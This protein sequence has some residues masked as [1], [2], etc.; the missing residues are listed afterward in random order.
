M[1]RKTALDKLNEAISGILSEYADDVAGNLEQ[2]AADMGKKGA[3]ALRSKS[4]ETFPV[5]KTRKITG[6]YAKGWKAK[7]EK[8]RL[9]T[10]AIIYNEHPA[11]PHLLENGHVSSNGTKRKFGRVPGYP[12]IKPVAD[13]LIETFERE[14]VAKL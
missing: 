11:L 7:T 4:K 2:I 8:D 12:H 1:A 6:E 13:E 3:Q 9:K 10:V 14:V 5:D